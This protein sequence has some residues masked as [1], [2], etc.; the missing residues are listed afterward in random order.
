[1]EELDESKESWSPSEDQQQNSSQPDQVTIAEVKKL[2]AQIEGLK[3][4]QQALNDKNER[5]SE[6]IGSL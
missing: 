4:T 3:E 2:E 6:K 1:V 5:I